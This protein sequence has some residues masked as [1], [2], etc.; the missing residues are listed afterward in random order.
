MESLWQDAVSLRQIK[1][2]TAMAL[3]LMLKLK[4]P[5][6]HKIDYVC[7]KFPVFSSVCMQLAAAIIMIG[8]VGVI[9][10]AGGSVIWVF[11]KMFGVM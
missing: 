6:E 5:I 1:E 2:G 11:Y 10:L 9:A 4:S 7:Q 3:K 8:A